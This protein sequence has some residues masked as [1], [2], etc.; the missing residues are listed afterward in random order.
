MTV[1]SWRDQEYQRCQRYIDY[2]QRRCRQ[3][4][5]RAALRSGLRRTPEQALRMHAVV[6]SWL[7]ERAGSD[8]E[9]AY[10]TVAAL[11]AGQPR[12]GRDS[13]RQQ[14]EDAPQDQTSEPEQT[15]PEPRSLGWAL[16]QL[17]IQTRR[18]GEADGGRRGRDDEETGAAM[19]PL[20]RRLHALSRQSVNGVHRQLA[21]IVLRLRGA[22][23]PVDWAQL[24][25]DLIRWRQE[26]GRIAKR[27]LQD[28]YRYRAAATPAEQTSATSERTEP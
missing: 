24:L 6:T 3:P 22:Q 20:E 8:E 28:F 23:I 13:D 17:E 10:Y 15:K 12:A 5:T 1:M 25:A 19:S 18:R 9:R 7:P 2:I 27:W 26:Q 11:I 16:A 4:G 21:P 14:A